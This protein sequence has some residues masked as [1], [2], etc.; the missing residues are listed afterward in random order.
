MIGHLTIRF[1]EVLGAGKARGN[2]GV[3]SKEFGP[4]EK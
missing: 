4:S 2:P 3:G 1:V